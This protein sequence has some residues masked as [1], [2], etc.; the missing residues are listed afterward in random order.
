MALRKLGSVS[1]T[2]AT[3][4]A[5]RKSRQEM[6]CELHFL[7]LLIMQNKL[8]PDSTEVIKNLQRGNIWNTMVTGMIVFLS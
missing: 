5:L 3:E 4:A 6:E 7:A 8:R 2:E 1:D